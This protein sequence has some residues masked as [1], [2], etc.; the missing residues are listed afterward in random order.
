MDALYE[1]AAAAG[2][3]SLVVAVVELAWHIRREKR[4]KEKDDD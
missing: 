3:L 4:R 1:A 2:I